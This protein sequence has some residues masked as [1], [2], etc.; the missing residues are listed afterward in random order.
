MGVGYAERI[1][2]ARPRRPWHTAKEIK[3]SNYKIT[4]RMIG[5]NPA[6]PCG[7]FKDGFGACAGMTF[8]DPRLPAGAF[9]VGVSGE[10]GKR[11]RFP[12]LHRGQVFDFR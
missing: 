10:E 6:L 11:R 5:K 12:V 4:M 1:E 2:Q 9:L 8:Y 7:A 3:I